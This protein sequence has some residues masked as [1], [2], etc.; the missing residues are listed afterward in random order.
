MFRGPTN[1]SMI[2]NPQLRHPCFHALL[3][4]ATMLTASSAMAAEPPSCD[5]PRVLAQIR[6]AYGAAAQAYELKHLESLESVQE[7]AVVERPASLDTERNRALHGGYPW[8]RSRF[9]R[10]SLKLEAGLPD[11]VHFRIDGLKDGAEDQYQLTP[12]FDGVLERES[13]P[14]GEYAQC[15]GYR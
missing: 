15:P 3:V 1:A 6:L 11:R 13:V 7:I 4:V 10:A 9:C 8:S 14:K 2:D 5:D 12:C